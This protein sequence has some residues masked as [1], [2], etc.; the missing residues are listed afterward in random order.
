MTGIYKITNKINGKM[1][2][3]QS[4]DI[5][6]R[7]RQHEQNHRLKLSNFAIYRAFDKYGFENFEFSV[8]EETTKEQ[9]DEREVYWIQT[10]HT[11][12]KD[13][14]CNGYNMTLGGEGNASID[15]EIVCALWNEG[16]SVIEIATITGHDRSAVRKYLVDCPN[17]NEYEARS[18]GNR[19]M[20]ENRGESVEQ[21]TLTGKYIDTYSNLANAERHTG[22]SA[23]NIWCAVSKKSLSAGG[24]QWKYC[25][26]NSVMLDITKKTK[27]QRQPVVRMN[28]DGTTTIYESAAE[29]SRQTG[30]DATQIR[31]VCQGKSLTAGG[32]KWYYEKGE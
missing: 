24:Y 29:A 4:I 10:L 21:Y 26:D 22:V 32:Y 5:F 12:L 30:I 1:Y 17:Y 16:K 6:D 23:K 19:T 18:R 3:G 2:V 13:P 27:K 25:I 14:L 31:R 20:W 15:A 9:L 28:K 8:I 11:Y 7:W